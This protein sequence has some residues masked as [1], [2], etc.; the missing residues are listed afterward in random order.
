MIDKLLRF[1]IRNLVTLYYK[2]T[3]FLTYGWGIDEL[4]GISIL[5]E[6][7]MLDKGFTRFGMKEIAHTSSAK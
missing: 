5:S 6:E 2:R 3:H 1:I 7:V 4:N